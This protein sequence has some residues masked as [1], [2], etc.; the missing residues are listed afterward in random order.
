LCLPYL[1]CLLNFCFPLVPV[2]WS[3]FQLYFLNL[4]FLFLGFKFLRFSLSLLNSPFTSCFVF[5]NLFISL[6]VFYLNHSDIFV[7]FEFI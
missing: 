4:S 3:D 7:F 5:F 1:L 6:F 2:C